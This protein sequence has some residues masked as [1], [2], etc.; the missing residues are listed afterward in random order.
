[1]SEENN[2]NS[3]QP[4]L[5]ISGFTSSGNK[6][7]KKADNAFFSNPRE[8]KR[9]AALNKAFK[10]APKLL[11]DALSDDTYAPGGQQDGASDETYYSGEVVDDG[12]PYSRK[13]LKTNKAEKEVAEKQTNAF[14]PSGFAAGDINNQDIFPNSNKSVV[15]GS[16]STPSFGSAPLIDIGVNF[17]LGIYFKKK[18]AI[19]EQMLA[20]A[21][22]KPKE[23]GKIP[24]TPLA[25]PAP[26]VATVNAEI[27]DEE[28]SGLYNEAAR[29]YGDP[30]KVY[31]DPR[32][33]NKLQKSINQDKAM[34]TLTKETWSIAQKIRESVS[35]GEGYFPESSVKA[36]NE[37]LD[38]TGDDFRYM[39]MAKENKGKSKQE[40]L[41]NWYDKKNSE[42]KKGMA[43]TTAADKII[44]VL[45]SDARQEIQGLSP[46]EQA[47]IGKDFGTY[48]KTY[49]S[50]KANP[51]RIKALAEQ[52]AEESPSE[53]GDDKSWRVED[54]SNFVINTRGIT[55]KSNPQQKFVPH[56]TNVN[57]AAQA[58]NM[59]AAPTDIEQLYNKVVSDKGNQVSLSD[60]SYMIAG[61]NFV[62]FYRDGKPFDKVR[63]DDW[64][65]MAY[66]ILELRDKAAYQG[67][68]I[69][70]VKDMLSSQEGQMW[71]DK[72]SGI[73]SGK[74]TGTT[75]VEQA[76]KLKDPV[77][78]IKWNVS[79]QGSIPISKDMYLSGAN[80]VSGNGFNVTVGRFANN[81]KMSG[82]I[83]PKD[84]IV[85]TNNSA[86][87]FATKDLIP[88]SDETVFALG[89]YI[90]TKDGTGYNIAKS[91]GAIVKM[92]T[93]SQPLFLTKEFVESST[94]PGFD[95]VLKADQRTSSGMTVGVRNKQT[96][97]GT[98]PIYVQTVAPYDE[99]KKAYATPEARTNAMSVYIYNKVKS[100]Q[101]PTLSAEE[102][103]KLYKKGGAF[104]KSV[105]AN[106]GKF[107]ISDEELYNSVQ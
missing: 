36:A 76:K 30:S 33:F 39:F 59:N 44:K 78:K 77:D 53:F 106:M 38:F 52:V 37:V 66:N 100:A 93:T 12:N 19:Q 105:D 5:K 89:S 21:A 49:L 24:L 56:V 41:A 103:I 98:K 88:V 23:I 47:A 31:S 22:A 11:T 4:T 86:F 45:E 82:V 95:E 61:D 46:T 3:N 28:T 10:V 32:L 2:N 7:D 65:N 55:E 91:D 96:G 20:L 87:G 90:P 9:K 107:T 34:A 70:D 74:Y 92:G 29:I 63:I 68:S 27:F 15:A 101:Q 18:R 57:V 50:E 72:L 6:D 40:I 51:E 14:L 102:I 16:M 43:L 8:E 26:N 64:Q 13:K 42:F 1:M 25:E 80:K 48:F 67:V 97:I 83:L 85:G 73:G 75:T 62:S 81:S 54:L 94:N 71:R 17:P 84:V 35:K 58:K 60:N 99:K 79:Q 69:S 104:A